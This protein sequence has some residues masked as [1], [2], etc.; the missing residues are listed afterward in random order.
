MHDGGRPQGPVYANITAKPSA[1]AHTC[2][3]TN[4]QRPCQRLPLTLPKTLNTAGL[5]SVRV[6]ATRA[7]ARGCVPA[8][9]ANRL[10][11]QN[12]CVHCVHMQ[13]RM[14]CVDNSPSVLGYRYII[15]VPFQL[16]TL[17]S[18]FLVRS[19]VSSRSIYVDL[20]C[21]PLA[22]FDVENRTTSPVHQNR[23]SSGLDVLSRFYGLSRYHARSFRNGRRLLFPRM[24]TPLTSH[25]THSPL[26]VS[27]IKSSAAPVHRTF[28]FLNPTAL[29]LCT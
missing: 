4:R 25:L 12:V 20:G 17:M 5:P 24:W 3:G 1:H 6:G 28:L 10:H 8:H 13:H 2:V 19:L 23:T 18:T 26:I 15:S 16:F 11:P 14:Y 22:E 9:C 27:F 29:R 21:S 7:V